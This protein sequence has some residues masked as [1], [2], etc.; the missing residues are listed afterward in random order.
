M[1][2]KLRL[3]SSTHGEL[4]AKPSRPLGKHGSSLW[5]RILTEYQLEDAGGLELL[6]L[7]CEQLDRCE[8]MRA[9]IDKEGEVL[10]T[11]NGVREHPLL[12]YELQARA[13]VGKTL[14]KLGL[15]VEPLRPLPGRPAGW[16]PP[17]AD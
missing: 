15:N 11:R 2:K 14:L 9:Q 13:F 6:L 4:R 5:H 16:M 7:A 1:A 17:D 3:V 12:R 10:P 8:V